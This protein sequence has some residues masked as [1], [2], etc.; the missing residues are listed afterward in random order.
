MIQQLLN[1]GKIAPALLYLLYSVPLAQRVNAHVLWQPE[2]P[3]SP[4]HIHPN[5]LACPVLSPVLWR[6]ENPNPASVP[7]QLLIQQL[8]EINS[9]SLLGFA[10][11]HPHLRPELLRAELKHITHAQTRVSADPTHQPIGWCEGCKN[12]LHLPPQKIFR[13]QIIS[14]AFMRSTILRATSNSRFTT[15]A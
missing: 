10:L 7:A 9:L 11:R 15:A 4:L 5:S 8:R 6:R 2:G 13:C 12:M 14:S 3:G 1:P